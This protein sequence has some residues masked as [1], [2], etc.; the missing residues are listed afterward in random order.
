MIGMGSTAGDLADGTRHEPGRRLRIGHQMIDEMLD[1]RIASIGETHGQKIQQRVRRRRKRP[2]GSIAPN[3]EPPIEIAEDDERHA[4][5]T[6]R[7]GP[8]R[9]PGNLR[10]QHGAGLFA[11][12]V[13][14]LAPAPRLQMDRQ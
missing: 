2:P 8:G 13:L 7:T 14:R 1:T 3:G 11:S 5:G 6:A 12:P 10:P 9:E 4:L